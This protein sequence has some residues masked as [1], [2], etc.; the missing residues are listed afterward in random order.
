MNQRRR[1]ETLSGESILELS[2]SFSDPD[3]IINYHNSN[4][5]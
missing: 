4:N 5:S 3:H 2:D 1:H